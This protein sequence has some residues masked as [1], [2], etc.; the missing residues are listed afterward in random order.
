LLVSRADPICH[1]VGREWVPVPVQEATLGRS[2]QMDQTPVLHRPHSTKAPSTFGDMALAEA[3]HALGTILRSW[4]RF[5][6]IKGAA[7]AGMGLGCDGK[8]LFGLPADAVQADP[9]LGSDEP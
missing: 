4:G 1:A 7:G 2:R 5:G 6:P 3:E 9:E 8:G